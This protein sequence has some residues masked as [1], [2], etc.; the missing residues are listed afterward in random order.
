MLRR[1]SVTPSPFNLKDK[2]RLSQPKNFKDALLD[3][4][5]L[6]ELA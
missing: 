1:P 2:E 3:E 4:T 6:E 5:Q